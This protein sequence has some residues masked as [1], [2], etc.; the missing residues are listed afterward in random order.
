MAAQE[1]KKQL[2]L[3]RLRRGKMQEQPCCSH[4]PGTQLT[5]SH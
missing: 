5:L 4:F 1:D 2:A 3:A